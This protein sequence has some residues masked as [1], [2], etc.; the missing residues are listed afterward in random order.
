MLYRIDPAV[1]SPLV[2]FLQGDCREIL[3]T[4]PPESVHCIV[5][6]P[7]FY[8]LRDFNLPPSVWGGDSECRHDFACEVIDTEIGK[9][10]WSQGVNGRGELQPGGVDAKREPIR[11]V[12]ERGFCRRCG[13]WRGCLGLEPTIELYVEHLVDIFREVKRVLRKDGTLW[14]NLGDAMA[15]TVNGRSAAATKSLGRDDR[16]FR[17]KPVATRGG[18]LKPKDLCL[19]PARVAIALQADGWFVRSDIVISKTNPMPESITDRP[20][21]S[22]EYM[23]LLSKS[24]NYFYDGEAIREPARYDPSKTKFPDGWDTGPGAHG[25]FHRQGR[26]PG[27][28]T[29]GAGGP[30]TRNKRSVWTIS[31]TKFPEAHFATFPPAMIE[32]C[33]LAGTSAKGCCVK[34][35][36]PWVR[37]QERIGPGGERVTVAATARYAKTADGKP[38]M[39]DN[40]LTPD[41]LT[42]GGFNAR[43]GVVRKTT[44]GWMSTCRCDAEVVPC[45]VLDPFAG[46]MTVPLVASR[47]QRNCIAIEMNPDYIAIGQRRLQADGSVFAKIVGDG[48]GHEN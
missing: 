2:Q 3:P 44:V 46:A 19:M 43:R 8:G 33:I 17:D 21:R 39:G 42:R 22:H 12:A 11:S 20:T 27:Q 18:T 13:A 4:L 23:F 25:S 35:G 26:E 30:A 29:S 45:V 31:T 15:S 1:R 41:E 10:N 5:T 7:P 24:P 37:Q 40:A 28:K 48:C 9:G 38:L 32:P 14:L 36:A 16:T 47:L 6:S 34:C